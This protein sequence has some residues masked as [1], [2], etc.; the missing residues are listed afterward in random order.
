MFLL[1][2]EGLE[3]ESDRDF[4]IALYQSHYHIAHRSI[5]AIVGATADVD[6]LCQECFLR[7]IKKNS[8]LRTVG[9]NI[10]TGYVVITARNV[11]LNHLKH[12]QV[13]D[14]H[15]F[16]GL[17]DDLAATLHRPGPDA[18]ELM[19]QQERAEEMIAIMMRLSPAQRDAF[20][21]KYVLE[22]SHD[23]IAQNLN[24]SPDSVRVYLHRARHRMRNILREEREE[25]E[26]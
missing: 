21:M 8:F 5:R 1:A 4:F 3:S 7:L 6:D 20:Y 13:Q 19:A 25:S 22:L 16:Y 18:A 23:Q 14:K 24:L 11:A 12:S 26:Q 17:E 9:C 15:M 2:L 10:L